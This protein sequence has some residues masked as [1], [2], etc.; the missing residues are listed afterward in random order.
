M[1]L[2]AQAPRLP[3]GAAAYF[4]EF[5]SPCFSDQVGDAPSLLYSW[6]AVEAVHT[7]PERAE[8]GLIGRS[9]TTP[10]GESGRSAALEK[11]ERDH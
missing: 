6:H 9:P 1:V 11:G 2:V 5:D 7:R 8:T 3:M 10:V 4:L